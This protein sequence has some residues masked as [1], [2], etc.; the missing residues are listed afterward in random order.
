MRID[1]GAL[2]LYCFFYMCP[3]QV[4]DGR[5][6]LTRKKKKKCV[7]ILRGGADAPPPIFL[8][9]NK[10]RLQRVLIAAPARGYGV[11][12]RLHAQHHGVI[13]QREVVCEQRHGNGAASARAQG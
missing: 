11:R 4:G 9:K 12:P 6:Y 8:R 3:P 5:L 1:R 2:M 10:H 13:V 7:S